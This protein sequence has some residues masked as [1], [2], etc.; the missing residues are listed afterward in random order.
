M[1]L[2]QLRLGP[3]TIDALEIKG[4]E[5]TCFVGKNGSG[6]SL[7]AAVVAGTREPSAG[8]VVGRPQRCELISFERT[9]AR[10]E[11]ELAQ[12]ESNF[13]DQVDFGTTGFEILSES[14]R[15]PVEIRQVARELGLV[16]LLERGCR[17][18]S[19]GEWRRVELGR[20]LL[21]EVDLLVLDDPFESLDLVS[22][23]Q[24]LAVILA[25]KESGV[26]LVLCVS[27]LSS[28]PEFCE[29]VGIL[30]GGRVLHSGP[31]EQIIESEAV[32]QLFAF[33]PARL[34]SPPT[35]SAARI[36]PLIEGRQL[37]VRYGDAM[38]F[39]PFDWKLEAGEHTRLIGPNGSGK[40]TLLALITGDHPQCYSNHISVVGY[41]RGQ[42]ETIWDIKARIGIVSPALHRDYRVSTTALSAVVSGF[43]D[44]IGLYE[45]PSRDQ[46][47]LAMTW[48]DVFDLGGEANSSFRELSHGR[49][50]LVLIARALIKSP[51][52][53][54][55]DE[56]TAGLDAGN[57]ALVLC[58]LERLIQ[59]E[60]ATIL[61][62]S[63][64]ADERIV[65]L[66]RALMFV[67]SELPAVRYEV[68]TI[69]L[70]G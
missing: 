26:Q 6:K 44:S 35:G 28:V 41:R 51:M 15:S 62:V 65:G 46:V 59:L 18:F 8:Q 54:V 37:C 64:R 34:P 69:A 12:D 47:R 30:G 63:H 9:Q 24:M 20:A 70:E 25:L 1:Y 10:Y 58:Y 19:S 45:K 43:F 5:A 39:A 56:P 16:E 68:R 29:R 3:L 32:A 11:H 38:Q 36:S 60:V 61:F 13:S 17:Q 14:G 27:R 53:L 40:S 7:L 67:P 23:R 57:A 4:E 66:K 49:Q 31:R 2:S 48:L 55:L 22:T 42:G 33:D 21:S 50:R 52:L